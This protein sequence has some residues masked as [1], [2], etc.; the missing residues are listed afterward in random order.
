MNCLATRS[1]I[2]L[3]VVAPVMMSADRVL[4]DETTQTLVFRKI[5]VPRGSSTKSGGRSSRYG[6]HMDSHRMKTRFLFVF[7]CVDLWLTFLA[8]ADAHV[9]QEIVHRFV[10]GR[11]GRQFVELAAF[12]DI[13]SQSF[14]QRLELMLECR[15]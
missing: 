13:A 15:R 12:F 10:E 7:I 3:C 9:Q 11:G 5:A 4:E 1:A 6:T 14:F 8:D 2:L